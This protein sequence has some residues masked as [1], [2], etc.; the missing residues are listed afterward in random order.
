MYLLYFSIALAVS[1]RISLDTFFINLESEFTITQEPKL[2]LKSDID[3]Y[4]EIMLCMQL[5]QPETV[6]SHQITK[7]EFVPESRHKLKK[8]ANISYNLP[9]NTHALNQKN[10]EM[11]NKIFKS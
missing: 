1:G 5:S 11:C 10:N 8:I 3:F 9:G 4:T 6:L 2:N 7:S